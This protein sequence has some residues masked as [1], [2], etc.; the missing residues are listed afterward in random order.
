M[1]LRSIILGL[2]LMT[3]LASAA[4]CKK[5]RPAASAPAA[6]APAETHPPSEEPPASEAKPEAEKPKEAPPELTVPEPK[7]TPAEPKPK[8]VAPP[9]PAP[10]ISPRLTPAEQAELQRKTLEAIATAE[11]NL[12]KSFGKQLNAIQH[13]LVQKIRGFLA[14]SR[15]AIQSNDWTRAWTLAEKARVLSVELVNSLGSS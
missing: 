15:E 12:E 2:V 1:Q 8:P 4:G 9:V 5:H 7:P 11:K 6:S 10:K 14:Q 13:D 3:L